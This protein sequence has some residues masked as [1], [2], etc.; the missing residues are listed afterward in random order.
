MATS[1]NHSP[2]TASTVPKT[3]LGRAVTI[4]A[5][6]HQ[7][8]GEVSLA[9]V[10]RATGLPKA[11]AHRMLTELSDHG[12][13]EKTA[14]G[15]LRLGIKMFEMG[16]SEPRHRS[17]REAARPVIDGLRDSSGLTV[18]LAVLDDYDVVYLDKAVGRAAPRLPSRVGGRLP[19]HCTAVG[20]ALLSVLD[21]D[22]LYPLFARGLQRRTRYT[23]IMPGKLLAELNRARATGCAIEREETVVGVVCAAT[24]IRTGSDDVVGALSLSGLSYAVDLRRASELVRRAAA[25]VARTLDDETDE[26]TGPPDSRLRHAAGSVA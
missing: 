4:L 25:E 12:L 8:E 10:V 13:I 23:T 17:L 21:D 26:R 9:Q 2:A 3:V 14:T 6:L 19:S 15:S 22:R 5:A 11:T 16:S 1:A 7:S 20:R 24:P 18:H